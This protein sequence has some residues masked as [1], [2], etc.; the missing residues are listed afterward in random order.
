MVRTRVR[1]V[2]SYLD[3]ANVHPGNEVVHDEVEV[4]A[5]LPDVV[6]HLVV[7][8]HLLVWLRQAREVIID[9]L[10]VHDCIEACPQN[11]Y[12]RS[13]LIKHLLILY[14]LHG[15]VV[16]YHIVRRNRSPKLMTWLI[17][18]VPHMLLRFSVVLD[19]DSLI[20]SHFC[21]RLNN[22][23]DFFQHLRV[24]HGEIRN[25]SA[26]SGVVQMAPGC[27]LSDL[28]SSKR[29]SDQKARRVSAS[30]STKFLIVRFVELH[31]VVDGQ[32][33]AF[34]PSSR[35]LALSKTSLVHAAKFIAVPSKHFRQVSV[36]LNSSAVTMD[37]EHDAFPLDAD[38]Y[39]VA[40]VCYF[41][42][43]AERALK[44]DARLPVWPPIPF[45]VD[46]LVLVFPVFKLD[47]VAV[48]IVHIL[49][50]DF[51]GYFPDNY[52]LTPILLVGN[53]V[54]VDC[55]GSLDM[56]QI[57]IQLIHLSRLLP[58]LQVDHLLESGETSNWVESLDPL[59]RLVV[60]V[61]APELIKFSLH[62]VDEMLLLLLVLTVLIV[63]CTTPLLT[64]LL[65]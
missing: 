4:L 15:L 14:S 27:H 33:H 25:S 34:Y 5:V 13:H 21:H 52:S 64:L 26:H 9:L 28:Q 20:W 7:R 46:V 45:V 16:L 10:V 44:G 35:A 19:L 56:S 41:A 32:I 54:L 42:A 38:L 24:F 2:V 40:V 61:F 1:A 55:I 49:D 47:W 22:W 53:P 30:C 50:A 43:I 39:R 6:V 62:L 3:R 11:Q 12:R 37:K 60:V 51:S 57:C 48:V 65:L 31:D 36:M 59:V 23:S 58:C 29:R 63:L 18:P 8:Y 17:E